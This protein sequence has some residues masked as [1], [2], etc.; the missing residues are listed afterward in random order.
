MKALYFDGSGGLEW[1]DDPTPVIQHATDALVRPIAVSTC[2]LDQAI[3]NGPQPVPGS[4]QPF[5][6]GHE[7]SI[8]L[9]ACDIARACG[10]RHVRYV[11]PD[12]KRQQLARDFGAEASAL[13]D[14]SP[15][16]HQY[17]ISLVTHPDKAAVHA[18]LF[19][20]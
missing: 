20:T 16:Q 11:D 18:A 13:A 3:V 19:A 15:D 14:F 12:P 6:I 10:A 1:K 5:A 9:F 4:E 7:G 2:D 8:G 17:E